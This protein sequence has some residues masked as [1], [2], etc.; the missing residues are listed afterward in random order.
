[1]E[2]YEKSGY[3]HEKFRLF[4]LKDD[5]LK[6][7][8]LHYHDF[9]KIMVFWGGNVNYMI[10]G[11]SYPLVP[12]DIVLV[13]RGDIHKPTV[14]FSIPYERSIFYIAPDFLEEYRRED[15]DPHCCFQK[16][17]EEK[18]YCLRV[19]GLSEQPLG[20][21]LLRLEEAAGDDCYGGG[22]RR[23]L[24]LQ[25]FLLELNRVCR[26]ETAE[27]AARPK[28]VYN[29]KVM[30]LLTYIGEHL[31]EPL[32]ADDLAETFYISKYHM[33]RLFK[34]ETGYT[35]HRYIT[36]KRMLAAREKLLAGVPA[37]RASMECGFQDYS[38]FLRAFESC[39][40]MTPT[41]FLQKRL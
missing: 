15:Y 26:G 23:E 4:H 1:M 30:A 39:F 21:A 3:L 41:A 19:K 14:D 40:S 36:E 24:L 34:Q 9:D 38:T 6:E 5:S 32:T 33:M 11:K 28:A 31:F 25:E 20:R 12:G 10:E 18:E 13:N 22:V 27:E 35:I 17:A 7:V 29:Q 37:T 8:S 2:P 16:A